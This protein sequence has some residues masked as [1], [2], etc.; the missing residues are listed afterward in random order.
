MQQLIVIAFH[1]QFE[2]INPT[3]HGYEFNWTYER[4]PTPSLQ[5][6][7][8][9]CLTP[10]G[11]I[12]AG[13]TFEVSVLRRQIECDKIHGLCLQMTF[14]FTPTG[15]ETV[16]SL[17]RFSIPALLQSF[18]LVGHTTEPA[19]LLDRAYVNFHSLKL[20]STHR[21]TV[22]LVNNEPTPQSFN[23]VKKSCYSSGQSGRVKV[24]PLQGTVDPHSR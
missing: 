12:E 16:E 19:V 2:I 8:F 20:G 22:Y 7:S 13:K 10:R 21:E 14:E 17:W 6:S 15:K 3:L 18:L 24:N 23:F 9:K 1:R 4:R 5:P 11:F